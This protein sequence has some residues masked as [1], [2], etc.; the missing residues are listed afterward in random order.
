MKT[1][2]RLLIVMFAVSGAAA[3]S[4]CGG[5]GASSTGK[6]VAQRLNQ[7]LIAWEIQNPGALGG[8]YRSGFETYSYWFDGE[9]KDTHVNGLITDVFPNIRYFQRG[10]TSVEMT[11]IGSLLVGVAR[12][13]FT[14]EAYT[15]ISIYGLEPE[16]FDWAP[17]AGTIRQIWVRDLL[18]EWVIAE[19]YFSKFWILQD[20]PTIDL[21][22]VVPDVID[23]GHSVNITG[24]VHARSNYWV[25]AIPYSPAA[26][27]IQPDG[28]GDWGSVDYF[29][30]MLT[31]SEAIGGYGIYLYTEADPATG[32]LMIGS[33]REAVVLSVVAPLARSE[34]AQ[35]AA[36]RAGKP[37]HTMADVVRNKRPQQAPVKRPAA[38]GTD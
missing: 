26:A 30:E 10:S 1:L 25:L 34:K 12:A 2:Y 19:E 35:A 21:L 24:R 23:P 16:I 37:R 4:G 8:F 5:G 3:L 22:G 7:W 11:T 38:Q 29:G 13:N 33:N 15:A 32:D 28:I 17:V 27:S 36:M 31:A 14:A 20:T 9:D 6:Q 18:N